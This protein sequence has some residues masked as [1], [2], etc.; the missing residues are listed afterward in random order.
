MTAVSFSDSLNVKEI[1]NFENIVL[2]LLIISTLGGSVLQ[3]SA[4]VH[5]SKKSSQLEITETKVINSEALT[6]YKDLINNQ[7]ESTSKAR[8]FSEKAEETIG[9][10]PEEFMDFTLLENTEQENMNTIYSEGNQGVHTTIKYN[11]DSNTYSLFEANMDTG[12]VA[13]IINEREFTVVADGEN[14]NIISENG[15]VLPLLITEY[16]DIPEA[17][18]HSIDLESDTII[19]DTEIIVPKGE[20]SMMLSAAVEFGKEY[21]PFKKTNK[22]LVEILGIISAGT[23][24]AAFKVKHPALGVISGITGIAGTIGNYAY[25]T[26]YIK[27]WQ[28][29]SITDYTYVRE[30]SNYYN[31]NNYTG[32]VK[33]RTQ[34]FYSSRPY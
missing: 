25:K 13:I 9:D 31:Y 8:L 33:S 3:P 14:I 24:A 5:A 6:I 20:E 17:I 29:H 26:L 22:T 2:S 28:S 21:G 11:N 1:F 32:F 10:L 19:S 16:E 34:H 27:Y 4:I 12:E 15:E 18:P 30:R 7:S 23:A